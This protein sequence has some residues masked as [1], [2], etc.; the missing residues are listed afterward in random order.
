MKKSIFVFI[1]SL[2]ISPVFASDYLPQ[3]VTS[4]VYT[5]EQVTTTE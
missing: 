1:V 2:L 5:T 4:E 3:E